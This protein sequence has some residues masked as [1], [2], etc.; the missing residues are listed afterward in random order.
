[1][2]GLAH[3]ILA[4][5]IVLGWSAAAQAV[6]PFPAECKLV[7]Q[8]SLPFVID[9]GHVVVDAAVNDH[10]LHFVVDTGGFVSAISKEAAQKIG[11]HPTPIGSNWTIKDAGGAESHDYARIEYLSLAR[12]RSE[13]L[14]LMISSLSAGEDGILAPE[15]LRN[16]DIELDF[17]NQT[18][19]LFKQPRCDDH[20]VYWTGDFVKLPMEITEQGHIRIPVILNGTPVKAT[21]DTGAPYTLVGDNAAKA[22]IG[23][24]K[25]TAKVVSLSG[26]AGGKVH[27]VG[28]TADSL[29]IGKFKFLSPTL[30][31]TAD[32]S[33]WHGSEMLLGLDILHDLHVF[34]DYKGQALYV[35]KR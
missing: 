8:A 2:R 18:M 21:V 6:E 3:S 13:N 24:G 23:E 30:I 27:G 17:A 25:Q 15:L 34:I 10:P 5:A 32:K 12:F 9:R 20:V 19:N 16:F 35:S 22:I 29:A 14:T 33:G 11:L 31:S 28:V 4:F 7:L 1:M 26:G